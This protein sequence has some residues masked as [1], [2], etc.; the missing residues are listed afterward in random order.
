MQAMPQQ[1]GPEAG[2]SVEPVTNNAWALREPLSASQI[3]AVVRA[4]ETSLE[5]R[6]RYQF[7]VWSQSNL[8]ALLPHHL[9][10]CGAYSR[11]R[12]EL[13]FEAFNNVAVPAAVLDGISDPR[14]P[15]M[16]QLQGR[17]IDQRGRP[18]LVQVGELAGLSV[19]ALRDALLGAGFR[20][21][22]VHGV[23]RPQRPSEIESFFVLASCGRTVGAPQRA[24][25]EL[26][27][28]HL[29]STWMR[30]Q[31]QERELGELPRAAPPRVPGNGRD[32][33][34]RER[35]ILSWLR[36]GMSNQ[37]IG[38]VLG[39]SALTVKNHVQKILRKLGA[40]N[41]AQAVARAMTMNLLGRSPSDSGPAEIP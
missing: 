25:F 2:L 9:A 13:Q 1:E 3:E 23:A 17:W 38:E 4:A 19:E 20:E 16:Q 21:L 33:T 35:Q 37:Q 29:H 6:R 15:L 36:E 5:V 41:R 12:R 24:M 11:Q 22:L 39:I 26:L 30:V 7:F 27:M 32:I 34:E 31:A 10:V 18:A 14:C 28:P 40:A 8:Q